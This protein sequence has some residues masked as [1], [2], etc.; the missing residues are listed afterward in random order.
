[1]EEYTVILTLGRLRQ[2]YH[3]F[4]ASLDYIVRYC[5]KKIK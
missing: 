5:L 1:V 3:E 4:E 2:E